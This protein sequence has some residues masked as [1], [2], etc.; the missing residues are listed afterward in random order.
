MKRCRNKTEESREVLLRL[1]EKCPLVL[2]SNFYG[3]LQTVLGEFH[4]DDVFQDVVESAA[5]GIRKPDIAIYE[6]A[7]R[8]LGGKESAGDVTVVGD[9]LKN[10]IIPAKQL[11]CKTVWLKGETWEQG[12]GELKKEGGISDR[13]ITDIKELV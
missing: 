7:L 3:N 9:S 6:L 13:V 10:D 1:R 11:G 4:L 12:Y 5:V 8:T 2:C